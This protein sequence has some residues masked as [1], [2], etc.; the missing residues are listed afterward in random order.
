VLG[1]KASDTSLVEF[2]RIVPSGVIPSE[3]GHSRTDFSARTGRLRDR[4][5]LRWDS[6]ARLETRTKES[7][8]CASVM[9]IETKTRT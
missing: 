2:V 9:V 7:N 8:K 3:L 6:S 4:L 1:Q 5:C